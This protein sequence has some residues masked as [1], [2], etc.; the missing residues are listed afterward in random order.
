MLLSEYFTLNKEVSRRVHIFSEQI[1][2]QLMEAEAK[3]KT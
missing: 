1:Y 3:G 2:T